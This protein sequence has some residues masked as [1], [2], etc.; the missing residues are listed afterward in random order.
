MT[1]KLGK[2]GRKTAK[3]L[4]NSLEKCIFAAQIRLKKCRTLPKIRLKKC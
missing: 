1:S 3:Y 2:V 4:V